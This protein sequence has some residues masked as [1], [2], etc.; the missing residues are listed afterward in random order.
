MGRMNMYISHG[1]NIAG[2][3]F[4]GVRV[5][6][7][8]L[9]GGLAFEGICPFFLILVLLAGVGIPLDGTWLIFF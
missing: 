3:L 5:A 2:R 6:N 9:Q 4:Q 7:E 8:R 1:H